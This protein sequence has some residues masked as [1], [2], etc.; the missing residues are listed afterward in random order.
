MQ[1]HDVAESRDTRINKM[2]GRQEGDASRGHRVGRPGASD[3]ENGLANPRDYTFVVPRA[4]V[5]VG[6]RG[7]LSTQTSP[8]ALENSNAPGELFHEWPITPR[9]RRIER[10]KAAIGLASFNYTEKRQPTVPVGSR[11]PQTTGLKL[12]HAVLDSAPEVLKASSEAALSA[13]GVFAEG[14]HFSDRGPFMLEV[15]EA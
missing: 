8:D 4:E 14:Q 10:P 9:F 2:P 1:T 12:T 6:P 7:A 15:S 13:R 11:D 5:F 3:V